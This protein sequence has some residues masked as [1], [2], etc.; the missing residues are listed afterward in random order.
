[1]LN[2][3]SVFK[4]TEKLLSDIS[5]FR[6]RSAGTVDAWEF[7]PAGYK[8]SNTPPED[9]WVSF[10]RNQQIRGNDSH[11][12]FRTK[13]HT[14]EK[15]EHCRLFMRV[16]TGREN[17]WDAINP[18]CIVYLDGVMTT[19]LDTCHTD[20]LLEYDRDYDIAVYFY[21]GMK[22]VP[23]YF[24]AS[25]ILLDVRADRLWYDIRVPFELLRD[26]YEQGSENYAVTRSVLEQTANLIDFQ[27]PGSESFFASVAEA[28]GFIRDE[29]YGRRCGNPT[30]VV[31][32]IG[33]SH[34]DVAWLWTLEQTREKAQRTFINAL[35]L[36]EEYPEFR[37]MASQP[38]LY[39]FVKEEA[40]EVYEQVKERIKEGRWEA[41]GAMW[42]EADCNLPGGEALV[43]QILYG[44]QFMKN[45]FGVDSHILWLPD[46]F[47]YSA[48]LPQILKKC[49][50]DHFVTS[51]ISWNDTNRLP[52]DSFMWQGLDGTEIM[53][54]F[55]TTKDCRE[56]GH[57]TTYVGHIRPNMILGTWKM[58]QQKEYNNETML[59]YGFGDGGGGPTRTMME[60]SRRTGKGLPGLPAT[61]LTS[62]SEHLE[63]A[64]ANIRENAARIGRMPKWSG[65]LYLEF[66]RGTYTSQANNKKNNRRSEFL[67]QKAEAL[68][69]LGVL[70]GEEYPSGK[71]HSLWENILLHQFHDILPGSSIRQVYEE[72]D[73]A[74][75]RIYEDAKSIINAGTASLASKVAGS[76][77]LVYNSLGFERSGTISVNGETVET[78]PVPAFGWKV[79]SPLKPLCTVSTGSHTAENRYYRLT[80][81]GFGRIISLYDKDNGRE[82]FRRDCFGNEIR[83]YEDRP[84]DY[85]AWEISDYYVSKQCRWTEEAVIE[86]AE[87]GCRAGFVITRPYCKSK[88]TQTIWLYS[89]SR[90]IDIDTVIDWHDN[91]KLIKAVFPF[92]IHA[93]KAVYEVQYGNVERPT[94]SNTSWDAA[95]FEVCGH[96]WADMSENGYGVSILNDCKYG[97]SADENTLC[98]TLLK[99][100]IYPDEKADNGVHVFTYSIL[101]HSG[102]YRNAETVKE[103]YNLNQ[104]LETVLLSGDGNGEMPDEYS[105]IQCDCENIIIESVK[106]AEDGNDIIVRMY[107]AYDRR[108]EA[109]LKFGFDVSAVSLCD[110]L[111][112]ELEEI[113]VR[114]NTV[115]VKVRNFEIVTLRVKR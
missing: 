103:A 16:T 59:T 82:V 21:T 38:Q 54:D 45:E 41:E 77:L 50:V 81:D 24:K 112:N 98:L 71:I 90:R 53:T 13:V 42:L 31:D 14:P 85:D 8:T 51:K 110:M 80:V 101:P 94:T 22:D 76:G 60:Y 44:K 37:F 96:K 33:H 25:F 66:H 11:F 115:S 64:W 106:A 104:P 67:M 4:K 9:G 93:T 108:A 113:P 47:G 87:D 92:D 97:W 61:R 99:S 12:W 20:V 91:Q 107:D 52:V 3:N 114:A 88:I 23:V 36:M 26:C 28:D 1:M 18:Q 83:I 6:E 7:V 105:M 10:D 86:P 100:G 63:K 62:V 39:K 35:R 75:K 57:E 58:Y 74:Y 79:I 49:G 84:H 2:N 109:E 102:D 68:S 72:S 29:F 95:K 78:G 69:V 73:R 46:V 65:E 30:S 32:C 111:E 70:S 34:L 27:E 55:I 40:P 48:A 19:A 89:E 5:A 43:R 56:S 17:D 15:E